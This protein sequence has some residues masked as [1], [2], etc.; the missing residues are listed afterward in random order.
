[1]DKNKKK[2]KTEYSKYNKTNKFNKYRLKVS[3]KKVIFIIRYKKQRIKELKHLQ[4]KFRE[5]SQKCDFYRYSIY[6]STIPPTTIPL[7]YFFQIPHV[8]SL[9]LTYCF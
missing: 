1:M 2:I 3:V 8:Q 7:P 9:D 5:N 4:S 6:S